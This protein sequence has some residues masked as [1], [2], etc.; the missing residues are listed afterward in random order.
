MTASQDTS[1]AASLQPLGKRLARLLLGDYELYAVYGFD[2][3]EA[4]RGDLSAMER[5]GF[6]FRPISR[7]DVETAFDDGLRSRA[8]YAGEDAECFGIF[9]D[10]TLVC[11]QFYWHGERYRNARNF[12][13]LAENEAK[14]VE[15]Y[16][17]PH[18]RGHG[19][20]PAIKAYSAAALK[21]KGFRRIFSR[22]WHSHTA[23]RRA[24]E[25]AGWKH[26]A[27]VMHVYP[28]SMGKRL[29]LVRRH[30][31]LA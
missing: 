20:G 6:T 26:V 22:V 7:D 16:T 15:F 19:L 29:R 21:K 9:R 3:Q 24:N 11:A 14:S 28:F 4:D 13:P 2:L 1:P 31:P 5:Q 23:S 18:L 30:K 12:W 10:G 8:Y 27:T 17:V 25:K